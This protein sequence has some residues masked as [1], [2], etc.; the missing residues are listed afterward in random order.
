MKG[1]LEGCKHYTCYVCRYG[2]IFLIREKIS[3]SELSPRH[4]PGW[5]GMGW[6][7]DIFVIVASRGNKCTTFFSYRGF[8][9]S[10]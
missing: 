4:H 9:T 8:L 6:E 2:L 3:G 10:I 1:G 7:R 5:D